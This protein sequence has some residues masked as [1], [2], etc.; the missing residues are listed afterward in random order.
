ME[1]KEINGT[2]GYYEPPRE[3]DAQLREFTCFTDS[4]VNEIKS[5]NPHLDN[6]EVRRIVEILKEL[7][8]DIEM[9]N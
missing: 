4:S 2:L 9:S 5:L 8:E 1:R 3:R 6:D 7:D